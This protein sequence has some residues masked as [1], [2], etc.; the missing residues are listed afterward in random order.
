MNHFI[1]TFTTIVLIPEFNA[2]S[3][4]HVIHVLEN[5]PQRQIQ[6]DFFAIINI[7]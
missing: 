7:F 2:S 3:H 5:V 4:Y 6:S 1:Y